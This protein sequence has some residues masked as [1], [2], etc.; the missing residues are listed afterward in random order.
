MTRLII[1]VVGT[2]AGILG[3]IASAGDPTVKDKWFAMPG[4]IRG[5]YEELF[6]LLGFQRRSDD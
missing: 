3:A 4:W 6:G 2:V 5:F 1:L